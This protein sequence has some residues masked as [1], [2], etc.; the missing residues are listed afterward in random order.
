MERRALIEHWVFLCLVDA[1]MDREKTEQ[2]SKAVVDGW[3]RRYEI[4]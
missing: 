4:E 2:V 3:K 1:Q